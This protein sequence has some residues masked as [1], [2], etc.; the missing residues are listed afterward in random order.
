MYNFAK[1]VTSAVV[2]GAVVLGTLAFYPGWNK[3]KVNAAELYDSTSSINFATIL[4][5][6]VDYGIVAE[7]IEQQSHM[8]TTFATNL[9]TNTTNANNDVDYISSTA[10]F[11]IDK[12]SPGSRI[13]LG[14]TTASA[15]YIEGEA[16]V[17]GDNYD[18]NYQVPSE[19]GS[20]GNLEFG[21]E[22]NNVPVIQAINQ[23]ADVN[24]DRLQ[25]RICSSSAVEDVEKGWSYFINDRA[26][27]ETGNKYL[28]NP[29]GQ[30]CPNI[31]FTNSGVDI[32]ITDPEF[33][34]KVVY[35]NVTTQMMD[36]L[37][38]NGQFNIYKNPSSII[39]FNITE[40]AVSDS[41]CK[42][43]KP[44]LHCN[45]ETYVG[46]TAVKGNNNEYGY[47]ANS[48]GVNASA[49]QKYFN[50]TIIWNIMT[51]KDVVLDSTGGLILAPKTK[52]VDLKSGNSSG[53]I[54]TEGKVLVE[55]EFHFLYNGSSKDGYGQM[56]F[57]LTKGFT[58]KYAPHAEQVEGTSE[59]SVVPDTSVEIPEDTY[60]FYIQEYNAPDTDRG[61]LT[62]TYGTP[63]EVYAATN[64]TV[65]FPTLQFYC[66][67]YDTL[68]PEQRHFYIE[69]P[70]PG[71]SE[72]YKSRD[73]YFKVTEDP[74]SP[75]GISNSDGYID[76]HLQVRVDKDGHFTYFVD[77]E[78]VTGDGITFR[79][80]GKKY[81]EFIKMSGV[82]FDLGAFYNKLE[83]GLVIC[84]SAVTG[85]DEIDGAVLK[86]TKKN[87]ENSFPV[88][89][90]S[91][92]R[93]N[94]D[95]SSTTLTRVDSGSEPGADQILFN[96]SESSISY[97]TNS[98][99]HVTITGI[100]DGEYEL[101][102]ITTPAGYRTAEKISFKVVNGNIQNCS[103]AT[104]N[105]ITMIDKIDVGVK[106]AKEI[107]GTNGQ[108]LD[109]AKLTLISND[110][111]DLSKV[112]VNN[113]TK[114]SSTNDPASYITFITTNGDAAELT[115]L[116]AGRYTLI[117]KQAPVGYAMQK[118]LRFNLDG[119]GKVTFTNN[120]TADEGRVENPSSGLS[121]ITMLDGVHI[122][123]KKVDED[124]KELNTARFQIYEADDSFNIGNPVGDS[125]Y[126]GEWSFNLAVGKYILRE[127]QAPVDHASAVDYAFEVRSDGTIY[128]DGQKVVNNYITIVDKK[129]FE[130]EVA[131]MNW[132]SGSGFVNLAGA[133]MKITASDGTQ[134][135][136]SWT[137]T[138]DGTDTKHIVT[139]LLPG[140]TYTLTEITSPAGYK[141]FDPIDFTI[142]A[143]GSTCR[144]HLLVD[145]SRIISDLNSHQNSYSESDGD[146]SLVQYYNPELR[147]IDQESRVGT[148]VITKEISGLTDSS[149][150]DPESIV[151]TITGPADF[152]NGTGTDTITYKDFTNDTFTYNNVPEGEYTVVE[153]INGTSTSYTY[154]KTYINNTEGTS[155]ALNPVLQRNNTALFAFVNE[156]EIQRYLHL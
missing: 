127:E 131:K 32:D 109:N 86:I 136:T 152:N 123:L 105:T 130:I 70:Q 78:S 17:F 51:E 15:V 117:E 120:V 113:A 43:S 125:F 144:M 138:S 110:G 20:N 52:L 53:W 26:T 59:Q 146:I 65:T 143:N 149:V 84:K 1:R 76:I 147:I 114:E 31:K 67:N 74:S 18:P 80:Y 97:K 93:N 45:N 99:G 155:A 39:I 104:G 92:V 124:N 37:K 50:E 36:R 108:R 90:I 42:L 49:V 72:S 25:N 14:K 83:D 11:L 79:E 5:G 61:A 30:A 111:Y 129:G 23:N 140:V 133:T 22:Y 150:V 12:L 69:K 89:T 56:H 71:D 21:G 35:V 121:T 145:S 34:G 47:D 58:H 13:Y 63:K 29:D 9:F 62:S 91:A 8:E 101:E 73:F 116:P 85:G 119:S 98:S 151:F 40:S 82:Q 141:K 87:G 41:V 46:T 135:N 77:Y 24:V 122:Q 156:Y 115:G 134:G 66:E 139:G 103:S 48:D 96:S 27:G 137:W 75:V 3:G 16:S 33:N 102:E 142:T 148:L 60:K 100:P 64:G 132:V 107:L 118:E 2:A 154:K 38:E 28:L 94:D 106:I 128:H 88:D 57:A 54:V 81:G 44:V 4:G 126:G 55:C 95:G 7:S 19:G 153:T 112:T 6:A 68:T 10:L